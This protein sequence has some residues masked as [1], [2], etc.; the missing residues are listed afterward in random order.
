MVKKGKV[1]G[2]RQAKLK[3][4]QEKQKGFQKRSNRSYH[5]RRV[6]KEKILLQ[7]KTERRNKDDT[8][9]RCD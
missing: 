7:K 3:N 9:F 1:L 6:E 2:L 5:G 4:G 8:A